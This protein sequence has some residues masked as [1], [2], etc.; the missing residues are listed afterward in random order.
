MP[1]VPQPEPHEFDQRVRQP[2]KIFLA[3]YRS[4]TKLRKYWRAAANDLHNAYK[5]ICAYTCMYFV[6]AD[7]TVD[8]FLP[9]ALYPDL[10]YE[11]SN[12]RLAIS[13]VNNH[14]D[15][16]TDVVDPFFIKEGWFVMDFPSCIIRP[17]PDLPPILTE[18]IKTT[19]E[20]LKL[21]TDDHFVQGRC[22]IVIE[23]LD[24]QLPFDFLSRRYPFLAAEIQRQGGKDTLRVVFKRRQN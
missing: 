15:K 2:G 10:A 20:V 1:V 18:R 24:G 14:K 5:G 13:R 12:Y 9:Q 6:P 11:W 19:L 7:T 4:G 8:H 22:D 3:A 17:A 21:N 23:F 16:S